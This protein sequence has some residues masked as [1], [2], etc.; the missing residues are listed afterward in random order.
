MLQRGANAGRALARAGSAAPRAAAVAG[1]RAASNIT[2][3]SGGALNVPNDP[4]IPFIEARIG[5]PAVGCTRVCAFRRRCRL[6]PMA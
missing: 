5:A 2:I 3:G 6:H 1:A 4:I